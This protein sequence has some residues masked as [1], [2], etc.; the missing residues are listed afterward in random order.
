MNIHS[1]KFKILGI[2]M[3]CTLLPLVAAT[4][5]LSFY[6]EKDTMAQ[7]R[8]NIAI[9][10]DAQ[11]ENMENVLKSVEDMQQDMKN[12]GIIY[13]FANQT[14]VLSIE[15]RQDYCK[16]VFQQLKYYQDRIA[17]IKVTNQVHSAYVYLPGQRMLFASD[18]TY[19][20]DFTLWDV[21]FLRQYNEKG[22][23]MLNQWI[24]TVP[25]NYE[26]IN[27]PEN[28]EKYSKL[29][30]Y[31][32]VVRSDSGR[33]IAIF[34]LN[35]S[36]GF[37]D[38]YYNG[39]QNTKGREVIVC[40][41]NG[42]IYS[43]ATESLSFYQRKYKDGSVRNLDSRE[44]IK[45]EEQLVV[46]RTSPYTGW[47]FVSFTSKAELLESLSKIKSLLYRIVCLSAI[48]ALII[49]NVLSVYMYNPLKELIAYMRKVRHG[50]MDV[51]IQAKRKDEYGE[52]YSGFNRMLDELN[53]TLNHLETEKI[54]N[55]EAKLRLLQEQI[56]P[57]FLYN[58]LDT[59]FSM[60]KISGETMIA[61]MVFSL[62]KF[63]RTSLSNGKNI[64]TL[65]EA[66]ELSE[67][68]L[69]IQEIRFPGKFERKINIPEELL[70]CMVPKFLL[71]P[72][73]ENSVTHGLEQSAHEG[74]LYIEG[75]EAA[76][77]LTFSIEDNGK[78]IDRMELLDI[79]KALEESQSSAKQYFAIT[80]I[81][82]IIKLKY[83]AEYGVTITSEREKGTKVKITVPV[84]ELYK[85][86]KIQKN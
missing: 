35:L 22:T 41:K 80:N 61:K 73:V 62:S 8:E 75:R 81:N 7:A 54:L 18:Q 60:A 76:G 19:F 4:Q 26:T 55:R 2:L 34:A 27:Y 30:T 12:D 17:A 39:I 25:V 53:N 66:V 29:L 16:K 82:S 65:R 79:Q 83:G 33:I 71:Q 24:P 69:T 86:K 47:T 46:S 51:R 20:E 64:V 40:D 13:E 68:Y 57:H 31:C 15:K 58:T 59:I 44:Y 3:L 5:L 21:D 78:G 10:M 37:L 32:D 42:E 45:G 23:D 43:G 28:W 67:N 74:M 63:F 84:D 14:R 1:F 11:I 50:E 52:V 38:T 48:V 36:P 85:A 70:S 72:F 49:A 6:A 77:V 56:N 9:S